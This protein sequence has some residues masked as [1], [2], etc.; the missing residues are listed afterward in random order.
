LL[1]QAGHA[2]T[3]AENPGLELSFINKSIGVTIDHPRHTLP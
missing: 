3:Q 1:L 2:L